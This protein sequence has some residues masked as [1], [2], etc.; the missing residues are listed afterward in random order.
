MLGLE[1]T[2][3]LDTG[4]TAITGWNYTPL[5]TLSPERDGEEMKV[6]QIRRALELYENN[7]I[8]SVSSTAYENMKSAL[9]QI[10][11][12]ILPPEE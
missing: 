9:A 1:I 8:S 4:Y 3:D 10:E 11:K 6:L 7:H 5:Y 2:K 12:R